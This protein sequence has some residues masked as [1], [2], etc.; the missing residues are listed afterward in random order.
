MQLWW[1]PPRPGRRGVRDAVHRLRERRSYHDREDPDEAW[2]CC[3][4]WQRN[5][6][7]KWNSREFAARHGCR[8]PDLY[9]YGSD[10]AAGPIESM[11]EQFVIRPIRGAFRKGVHVISGDRELLTDRPA[12]PDQLRERLP[13]AR[14]LRPPV[15]H[16]FEEFARPEG[17]GR[18]LPVGYKCHTFGGQVGAVYRVELEGDGEWR[19][20]YY[21]PDWQPFD[22][23]MNTFLPEA[24]VRGP[25]GCLDEMLGQAERLGAELGTYMRIDFFA[26]DRGA[27]FNEFSSVPLGG[28]HNT[29]YCDELFGGLWA[30]TVPDAI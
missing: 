13:R 27:M 25:P 11:P 12:S 22:D 15:R 18:G 4:R 3:D 1:D 2:R 20:R 10:P 9:W 28:L 23:P 17:G 8:V 24:E 6:I 5:L 14:L 19:L 30:A 16:L 21:T 29:P 26:T 7:K